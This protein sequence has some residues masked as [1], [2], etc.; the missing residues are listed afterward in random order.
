MVDESRMLNLLKDMI[1]TKSENPPG[2]ERDVAK[3][4]RSH[5]ES[6]GISSQTVGPVNRPNLIFST[7]ED[8][9]GS[10]VIHGHMDTVPIGPKDS[11]VHDP[12][13]SEISDGMLYGRGSADM[14]GPVAALAETMILYNESGHKEPLV[15]LCT[16]DEESGCSGA[17]EVAASGL[18]DGIKFGVCA[19]P[20]SLDVLVG[21][22]G[23]FWSKVKANGKSAHGS[24][25]KEGIN[26]IDLCMDALRI[27]TEFDYPYEPNELLGTMTT[28]IGKIEGGIKVNV[29]P[30]YCEALV[31]MRI[32]MGQTPE[33]M[34]EI[35]NKT[36]E[37]KGLADRVHAEYVHGK[38]AVVTPY[39]AEIVSVSMDA[40]ER[41]TGR[42]SDPGAAT[43][44]TDCSVLQPKIGILNVICGPG[45]IEQ[46]HQPNEYI[47][48]S[49][50]SQAV[51]IY[52]DIANHFAN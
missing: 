41:V 50:M 38:P 27:L 24:R 7:S 51:K 16:S 28:N 15:M 14:K 45:S 4:I 31:D 43:Y 6:H 39:D 23:I 10:L 44:G 12:F 13:G 19:E 47:E 46:A 48:I 35:M 40:V 5:M 49:Q 17:E 3:V 34:L 25:P 36:L 2:Y 8:E 37:S 11:W 29:V 26:A 20:T 9:T 33:G 30:D 52:L 42:R 1:A 22:K 18:L 32:V 21:E